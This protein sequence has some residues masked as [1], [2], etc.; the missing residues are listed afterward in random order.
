MKKKEMCKVYTTQ[1]EERNAY[2]LL[3]KPESKRCFAYFGVDTG[4]S[5]CLTEHYVMKIKQRSGGTAQP[6][7]TSALDRG[8]WSASRTG[9]FTSGETF[10]GTTGYEPRR[11]QGTLWTL[12]RNEILLFWE[13][14]SYF[15]ARSSPLYRLSYPDSSWE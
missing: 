1:G 8:E 9:C 7:L 2:I 10:P 5:L 4:L 3:A 14:N 12:W 6:F 15:P 13:F 11:A